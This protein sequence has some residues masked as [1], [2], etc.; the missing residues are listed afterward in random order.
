M[1][2][3]DKKY[4]LPWIEKYRPDNLDNIVSHKKNIETLNILIDKKKF[5]HVVFYGPPGSGKTTTI[6][7]CIEKIYGNY[8]NYMVLELNASDDRGVETIR[9]LIKPFISSKIVYDFPYKI[10]VLDEADAMTLDAQATLRK[11]IEEYSDKT[12]FCLICNYLQNITP[13]LLSRCVKFKFSPIKKSDIHS[14]IENICEKENINITKNAIST[15]IKRSDGDMRKV[16][17]LLQS[18][19]I[20]TSDIKSEKINKFFGFPNQKCIQKIYNHLRK[21]SFK[22]TFNLIKK[23]VIDDNINLE[24]IVSDIT[25]ILIDKLISTNDPEY[26]YILQNLGKYEL[27]KTTCFNIDIKISSLISSFK[28][29]KLIF[30]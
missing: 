17:N 6:K 11:I 13:A 16:L 12:R 23:C 27:Y 22:E 25:N 21:N 9:N 18:V 10:V 26:S 4:K 15:L 7:S 28:Y 19:S 30:N 20:S 5:P 1:Q 14:H 3:D 24:N 2:T 8:A 29:K